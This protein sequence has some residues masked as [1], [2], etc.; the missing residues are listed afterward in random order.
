MI[1][2]F[3]VD[4][5]HLFL[6][7]FFEGEL[8]LP[9]IPDLPAKTAEHAYQCMRAVSPEDAIK[10]LECDTPGQ[11]KRTAHNLITTRSDWEEMKLHAMRA[12]LTLKFAHG[13]EMAKL[14]LDT[15]DEYLAEGNTWGDTYWGTVDDHGSNWLGILLMARRAELRGGFPS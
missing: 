9:W 8:V 15:G 2:T 5:E 6:S 1:D 10:V 7:N 13:S 12:T 14:L 4:G 11:A 3:V